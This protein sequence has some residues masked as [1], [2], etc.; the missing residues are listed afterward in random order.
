[1]K[2]NYKVVREL[3]Q[4]FHQRSLN[5]ELV[6][7]LTN[8]SLGALLIPL[9]R[10]ELACREINSNGSG[11]Q[12]K[13]KIYIY[14]IRTCWQLIKAGDREWERSRSQFALYLR[15]NGEEF[16]SERLVSG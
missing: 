8:H 13:K 14:I 12:E 9:R 2:T 15:Y 7:A 1:M 5:A 10:R 3:H 6:E 16:C 4:T 11:R